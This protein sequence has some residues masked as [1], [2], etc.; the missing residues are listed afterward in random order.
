[1]PVVTSCEV[2]E[3]YLES[4]DALPR[5]LHECDGKCSVIARFGGKW[6]DAIGNVICNRGA[7]YNL[8][9][10]R[11]DSEAYA[12]LLEAMNEASSAK[13][14]EESFS[15]WFEKADASVAERLP[16]TRFYDCD[17]GPYLTGG[18]IIACVDNV[19]NASIHRIM[20]VGK[21]VYGVRVVP[22]HLHA[23]LERKRPL[24]VAI[25]FGADPRV[26]LASACSPP[27]GV[28]E[29]G[30]A[31]RLGWSGRVCKTPLY[32]I[33]VSCDAGV[34]V[35]GLLGEQLVEEGPFT[36]ILLLCDEKRL[37]PS[38]RPQ[39]VYLNKVTE[40]FVWQI[41][42][43]SEEHRLLMG[44][45]R[46]ASIW[47]SVRRATGKEPIVRL[48]K[49]GGGWLNAVIAFDKIDDALARLAGIAA[50]A[51][52]PSVKNVIVTT[53][54]V[55]IDDPVDVEWAVA[56]RVQHDHDVIVIR[57]VR[58]STLDPSGSEG[59]GTKTVIVAIPKGDKSKFLKPKLLG[60][61]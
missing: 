19:C 58:G 46:E 56:T 1:M 26:E 7:L 15:E 36:D 40:R 21:G 30:V 39:A 13:L 3:E 20:R 35:E 9:G 41:L 22:R 32:G 8:L 42:P 17:G 43:G 38:F 4:L 6:F 11:K 33:P 54:D 12:K 61:K 10:A 53:A 57:G 28:F 27:L 49:G 2:R 34:V 16:A 25:V 31:V 45:P 18:V 55:N 24:P 47:D 48:T 23:L 37:Q 59:V 51:G 14:R 29:L 50:I 44:F 52:H 5:L 60:S